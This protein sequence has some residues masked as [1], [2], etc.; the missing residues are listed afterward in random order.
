GVDYARFGKLDELQASA[1]R[2]REVAAAQCK[3]KAAAQLVLSKEAKLRLRIALL[4]LVR[5]HAGRQHEE[6]SSAVQQRLRRIDDSTLAVDHVLKAQRAG[7]D[8]DGAAVV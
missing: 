8:H 3:A 2:A 5:L 1:V 6:G 7:I 4:L